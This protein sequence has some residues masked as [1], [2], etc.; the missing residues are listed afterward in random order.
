[1]S[2]WNQSLDL[3]DNASDD[4]ESGFL[5]RH[6]VPWFYSIDPSGVIVFGNRNKQRQATFVPRMNVQRLRNL[7]R[8]LVKRKTVRI[9]F[10]ASIGAGD[11]INFVGGNPLCV[12]TAAHVYETGT[13]DGGGDNTYTRLWCASL[14]E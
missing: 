9:N 14:E 3:P 8:C 12:L 1:M 4:V 2:Q 10:N 6:E 13:D 7:T 11:L 5:E